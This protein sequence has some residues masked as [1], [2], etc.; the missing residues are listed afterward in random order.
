MGS[1]SPDVAILGKYLIHGNIHVEVILKV[2]ESMSG[3]HSAGPYVHMP[4]QEA[5]LIRTSVCVVSLPSN[6]RNTL[7]YGH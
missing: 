4:M 1:P 5:K 2:D 7:E 6:I 3:L